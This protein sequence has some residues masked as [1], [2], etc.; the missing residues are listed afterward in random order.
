[1]EKVLLKMQKAKRRTD[2]E[3]MHD[4]IGRQQEK[5]A[6]RKAKRQTGS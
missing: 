1:M 2:R 5:R 6:E 3:K 4:K